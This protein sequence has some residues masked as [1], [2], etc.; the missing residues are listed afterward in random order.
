MGSFSPPL[1]VKMQIAE[2]RRVYAEEKE[3][4]VKLLVESVQEL[5][6]TISVLE[7]KVPLIF[8]LSFMLN[9]NLLIALDCL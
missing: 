2:S 5:D 9:F 6:S 4:E 8:D 7:D 3:E 1:P